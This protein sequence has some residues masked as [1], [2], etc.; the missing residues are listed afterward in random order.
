MHESTTKFLEKFQ[1]F[2][3]LIK[4]RSKAGDDTHFIDS[5]ILVAKT[6]QYLH[7]QMST[8]RDINALR[9]VFAHQERNKY[10]ASVSDHVLDVLDQLIVA[11]ENPPIVKDKFGTKV[12]QAATDD[13]IWKV[14]GEMRQKTFTHVPIWNGNVLVGVFSYSSLFEW[15]ADRQSYENQ[16]ITFE[17]KQ[18][19]DVNPKYLN[20][21]CVNFKCISE[22]TSIY[23]ISPMFQT[24]LNQQKRL[25][26]LLIS[27]NGLKKEKPTGIITSWDLGNIE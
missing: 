21:P 14:M 10:I 23:D 16:V 11:L 17:K 25:D 6:N 2:E 27:P 26:C 8:I 3:K 7:N 19:L 1:K 9:N 12:F 13:F 24:A 22:S 5:A 18:I 4:T 15:L 20:S